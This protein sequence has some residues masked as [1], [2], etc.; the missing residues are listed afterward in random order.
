MRLLSTIIV[1]AVVGIMTGAAIAYVEVRSDRD[2][3]GKLQAPAVHPSDKSPRAEIKEQHY[4]FGVMQRGTRKSH[5][6]EIRNVGNAPMTVRSGGTTCK[7][8]V[9]KVPDGT[10]PPGG[11]TTIK[12]EWTAKA[13]SGPFRQT[14]TILTDDP[15]QSQIEI[16]IDGQIQ[17]VSGI[18]P[19]DFAFDKLAVG[20]TKSV[21]V[22]VMAMLQ[23]DLTVS[24]AQFA[25]P[26]MR[27][28]F[29]VKIEPVPRE[30]LPNKAA[31]KGERITLT[32]KSNLPVGRF[33]TWLTVHTNLPE[34]EKLDIPVLGQV[35][36]DISVSGVTGW[37]EEQG[38]LVIGSVKSADGGRGRVNLIVRG[39]DA[40]NVKF[41][42]KSV[43]PKEMKVTIGEPKK[44]R[45][46]LLHVPVEIEIPAGTRPMV[47]LDT[48]QGDA[49]RIV[50]STTH[51]K[52]K[53]LSLGVRFAV[54]R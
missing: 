26:T 7:C 17:G 11:S 31:K 38:V 41:A 39:Q 15:L 48:A 54:E 14:A 46:N 25:D 19:A 53:E 43:E 22:Y 36:G 52:I 3:I 32:P 45:E 47:H 42:V 29:D 34:A 8:T 44:L 51:P 21:S 49:G 18:E 6:F 30:A 50:F 24:E 2:A 28:K 23:D 10:I 33:M 20:E 27:D 37:N 4:T 1:A 5:E 40:S 13:D 12:L 16:T 9:S 35:I